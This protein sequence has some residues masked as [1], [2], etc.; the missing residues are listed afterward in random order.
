MKRSFQNGGWYFV[1]VIGTAGIFS[2]VPFLHASGRLRRPD[3]R[4]VAAAFGL[5][6]LTILVVLTAVPRDE[7]GNPT[8]SLAGALS[9]MATVG[10]LGT[11]TTACWQLRP[12]RRLVYPQ[13]LP[14]SRHNVTAGPWSRPDGRSSVHG[15][16]VPPSD[17]AVAAALGARARRE[18]ARERVRADPL[19]ARDLRIGRPDMKR[20]YDDGGLLDL[21]VAPADVIAQ[22]VEIPTWA[23]EAIVNVRERRGIAFDNLYEVLS[24]AEIPV[25]LH[26]A[27]LDRGVLIPR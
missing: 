21:N 22:F 14:M 10:V 5:A 9:T 17:A 23:A 8:G 3:L 27:V 4:K 7:Q 24:L 15:P 6:G 1:L 20:T 13:E 2:A 25:G 19:L 12:V 16:W 11:V 18:E 26:A